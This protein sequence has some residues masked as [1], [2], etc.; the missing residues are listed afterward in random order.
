MATCWEENLMLKKFVSLGEN[1]VTSF[2][3]GIHGQQVTKEIDM[4][5]IEIDGISP[6]VMGPLQLD[7]SSQVP[8]RQ[9]ELPCADLPNGQQVTKE[10]DMES[11]EIDGISPPVMG[12]LQLDLSSQVPYRQPELPCADLPNGNREDYFNICVPLYQ[13]SSRCNWDAAKFILDEH[14]NLPKP[15]TKQLNCPRT[16]HCLDHVLGILVDQL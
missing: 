3:D 16:S 12:P 1:L 7:L 11:I 5:S 8:Y 2:T 13:A 6:P 10:I 9:P 4:E 15:L 14:P